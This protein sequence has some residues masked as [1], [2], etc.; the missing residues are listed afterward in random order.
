MAD[1]TD[2]ARAY[3]QARQVKTFATSDEE[4]SHKEK[5]KQL[6]ADMMAEMEFKHYMVYISSYCNWQPVSNTSSLSKDED[7]AKN[8]LLVKMKD[9]LKFEMLRVLMDG[10]PPL[11]TG[12]KPPGAVDPYN[13]AK[14]R[15]AV[16]KNR[17]RDTVAKALQDAIDEAYECKRWYLW[18]EWNAAIKIQRCWRHAFYNPNALLCKNRLFREFEELTTSS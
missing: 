13:M 16:F 14:L 18:D 5:L 7:K 6:K 8:L 9:A 17:K 15:I 3:V 11:F 10:A 12:L 1:F 4:T 2:N